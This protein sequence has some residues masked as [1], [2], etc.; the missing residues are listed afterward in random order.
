MISWLG[1]SRRLL[2][3]FALVS[4]AAVATGA[5]VCA[6]SGVPTSLWLRNLAAWALGALAA[7]AIAAAW[8]PRLLWVALWAGPIG[9]LATFF[10]TG[11]LGVH[12][13]LDLGPLHMNAAMLLAPAMSVAIA[14]LAGRRLWSWIAALAAMALLVAQPDAS[15]AAALGAVVALVAAIAVRRPVAQGALGLAVVIL[16]AIAWSRPDPLQPVPEVEGIFGLAFALSP[17][18]AG[19]AALCLA[20]S[21]AVPAQFACRAG[22]VA[23]RAGWALSLCFV[24]WAISPLLGAFPTPLVGIGLSPIIGAWL[25]VGLLAGL[26]R[27]ETE[28]DS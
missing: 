24:V 11:Q 26:L 6:L 3:L 15:Q 12:R 4:L 9:L 18:M 14:A 13:W 2:L 19:L 28:A 22:T 21:A 5:F 23:K 27:E 20:G 1:P 17:L 7:T 25:G 10:S 8:R 16:V